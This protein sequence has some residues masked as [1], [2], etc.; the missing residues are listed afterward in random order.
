[1]DKSNPAMC[2]ALLV[3]LDLVDYVN[4]AMCLAFLVTLDLVDLVNLDMCLALFL[5]YLNMVLVVVQVLDQDLMDVELKLLD[6]RP[7]ASNSNKP[8]EL[9]TTTASG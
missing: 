6:L 4:P 1:M 3:T 8:D 5:E 9:C 7:L 2:L